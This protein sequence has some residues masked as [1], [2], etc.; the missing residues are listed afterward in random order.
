MPQNQVGKS[1]PLP[2]GTRPRTFILDVLLLRRTARMSPY[3]WLAHGLIL[4]GFSYLLLFHALSGLV[5]ANL[6]DE[7]WPTLEPWQFLRNL[8]GY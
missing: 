5:S 6:V 4:A 8:A 3:R 7:Y 2:H 1:G